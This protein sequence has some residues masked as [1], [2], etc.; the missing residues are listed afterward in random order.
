MD[1]GRK[2]TRR[3]RG[4]FIW[5]RL[6]NSLSRPAFVSIARSAYYHDERL[7]SVMCGILEGKTA[8]IG[9]LILYG[10]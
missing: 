4:T 7:L 6:T 1:E 3:N 5:F 2:A 8:A 9:A 10:S